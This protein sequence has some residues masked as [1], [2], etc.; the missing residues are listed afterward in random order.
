MFDSDIFKT[1]GFGG[2]WG[3]K[4]YTFTSSNTNTPFKSFFKDGM[5]SGFSSNFGNDDFFGSFFNGG[6][7]AERKRKWKDKEGG[8]WGMRKESKKGKTIT[9]NFFCT[10]EELY[11]GKTKK[12]K[13]SRKVSSGSKQTQ[14]VETLNIEIKPGLKDGTKLTYPKKGNRIKGIEAGDVVLII[15]EKEHERFKRVKND[16]IFNHKI[17][18]KEAL[19]GC[20]VEITTLDQRK[21]KLQFGD[22]DN[23]IS[24]GQQFSIPNEG[25]PIYNTQDK[26]SLYIEFN[27][28]FPES[29][30]QE[31]KE[32]L[33]K[34]L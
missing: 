4:T 16:L 31:K 22:K 7:K 1:G 27:I 2:N 26:G 5:H 9:H 17:T 28:E 25:M 23:I 15:K 30:T 19:T 18:L 14:E 3:G 13:I 20:F 6:K 32:K 8:V 29:I 11:F 33:K 10:L 24:P 21:L 12:I 34:I